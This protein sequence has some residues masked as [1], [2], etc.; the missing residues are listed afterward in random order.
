MPIINRPSSEAEVE[1]PKEVSG[2][3]SRPKTNFDEKALVDD[4]EL[5]M[6]G[7]EPKPK[8]KPPLSFKWVKW[9]LL[10][11]VILV[12]AVFA[13]QSLQ[14][15][16]RDSQ[17]SS[18]NIALGVDR[19]I[20]IDSVVALLEKKIEQ[21]QSSLQRSEKLGDKVLVDTMRLALAQNLIDLEK[22]QDSFI[23]VLVGLESAFRSNSKSVVSA[24]REQLKSSTDNYKL[25]RVDTINKTLALIETVPEGKSP[26]EYFNEKVKK[27]NKGV[28]DE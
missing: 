22:H 10:A 18:E 15:I 6:V 26:L 11:L 27:Q 16:S 20:R 7:A 12:V 9:G 21:N 25:G 1:E 19:L 24:L 14:S 13:I 23:D 28:N 3:I 5:D 17:V 8:S 4:V 2:I